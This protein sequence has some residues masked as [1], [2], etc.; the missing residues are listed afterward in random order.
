M[1]FRSGKLGL[2]PGDVV[3]ADNALGR[4]GAE[5]MTLHT[6]LGWGLRAADEPAFR[7]ALQTMAELGT[8]I[9][10]VTTINVG[11][12]LGAR[13]RESDEPLALERW[14][15]AIGDVFGDRYTIACEPGTLLVAD[16]GVLVARVT[17]AW[18]KHGERWIGLDAGQSVNVY[19]AH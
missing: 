16:A 8:Q 7:R 13:L 2:T 4:E 19:A 18:T 6:H 12:G 11:G 9:P 3:A 15:A 14:A 5:T 10:T 17:A 1:L